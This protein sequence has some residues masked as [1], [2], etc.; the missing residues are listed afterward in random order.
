MKL[1]I[2]MESKINIKVMIKRIIGI[3]SL[4][5]NKFIFYVTSFLFGLCFLFEVPHGD[6]VSTLSIAES[7]KIIDIFWKVIEI[8]KIRGIV[9]VDAIQFIIFNNLPIIFFVI[10]MMIIM[11][12][13]LN[14]ISLLFDVEKENQLYFN[15]FISSAVMM[16]SFVD[17]QSA[18]WIVTT[19]CYFVPL[20]FVVISL[21]PI[22]KFIKNEKLNKKELII[23]AIALIVATSGALQGLAVMV[24]CY[25][26]LFI[27]CLIVKKQYKENYIFVIIL[28]IMA[29]ATFTNGSNVDRV[30]IETIKRM[31]MLEMFNLIS[32]ID[33]GLSSSFGWLLF[34]SNYFIPFA[35]LVLIILLY[36][37]HKSFKITLFGI[38]PEVLRIFTKKLYLNN[39]SINAF[40]IGPKDLGTSNYGLFNLESINKYDTYL[41][42]FVI[43]IIITIVLIEIFLLCDNMKTFIVVVLVL[44]IGFISRF[45]LTFTPNVFASQQRTFIYFN[46]SIILTLII[47]YS[48]NM[49]LFNSNEKK[50]LS[51]AYIILI[52][53]MSGYFFAYVYNY[54]G[55]SLLS[56]FKY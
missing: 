54:M 3:M 30:A 42:Y 27:Y 17:M 44:L 7:R 26:L 21:L 23:Y 39:L 53:I 36:K 48:K 5:E 2:T 12:L 41:L 40:E 6:D 31:P 10:Y 47:V 4:K 11:Y 16:Y 24:M 25:S 49:Y 51:I 46:F 50:V 1:S 35:F 13:L 15:I 33:I 29:I 22:K 18:G 34:G 45:I 8:I 38:I 32:R 56:L 37:K 19:C 52:I 14:N 9:S 20:V 28:I 55:K 43:C